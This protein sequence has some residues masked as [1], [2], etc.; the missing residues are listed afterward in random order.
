MK[1]IEIIEKY[2]NAKMDFDTCHIQDC[3]DN[4]F[5]IKNKSKYDFSGCPTAFGINSDEFKSLCEEEVEPSKQ[6]EQCR[7]C[8]KVALESEF[9]GKEKVGCTFCKSKEYNTFTCYPYNKEKNEYEIW[10]GITLFIYA[11][12]CPSCGRKLDKE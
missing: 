9:S 10:N 6:D 8:W 3:N 11:K 2:C 12:Y 4:Y 7:Q 1:G 5:I